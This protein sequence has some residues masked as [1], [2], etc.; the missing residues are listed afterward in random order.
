MSANG[1]SSTAQK[2]QAVV[3]GERA[4]DRPVPLRA[5]KSPASPASPALATCS[6]EEFRAFADDDMAIVVRMDAATN[7]LY[8]RAYNI[9]EADVGTNLV[10]LGNV[11]S[12][13]AIAQ[14]MQRLSGVVASLSSP[15]GASPGAPE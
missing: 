2:P 5:R 6:P 10:R 11:I 7:Q 1:K 3:N 9:S 4:Q 12:E 8:F 13:N 14:L 15:H